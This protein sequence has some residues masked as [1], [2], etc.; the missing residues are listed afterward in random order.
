MFKNMIYLKNILGSII[1]LLAVSGFLRYLFDFIS[2]QRRYRLVLNWQNHIYKTRKNIIYNRHNQLECPVCFRKGS[3]FTITC[4]H[5]LCPDCFSKHKHC[6]I[7]T[8]SRKLLYDN[9]PINQR[10]NWGYLIYKVVYI[11][12]VFPEYNWDK[13]NFLN[14]DHRYPFDFVKYENFGGRLDNMSVDIGELF[15]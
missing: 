15:S 6:P 13:D 8:V 10:I 12:K 3:F 11:S 7:C 5:I 1:L 9:V 14:Y 4:G 2:K